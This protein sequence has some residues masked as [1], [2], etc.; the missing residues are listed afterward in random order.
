[1]KGGKLT[2]TDLQYFLKKSYDKKHSNYKDFVLDKEL[3]GQRVQVYYNP[4]TNQAVVVH[5]GTQGLNDWVTDARYAL[6]DTSSTRFQHSANIQAKAEKKYGA[7]NVTSIGHSLGSQLAQKSSGKKVKEIIT[8]NK[9]VNANDIIWHS[10]PQNQTDIRTSFDPVS[11][12]RPL[13]RGK[14]A[15]VLPSKTFNPFLEHRTDVLGDSPTMYG[16]GRSNE[17]GLYAY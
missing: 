17:L 15:V 8:L 3:T 7:T 9:P 2:S 12:L 5:R 1:M 10:V 14:K 4:K 16:S 6:G 13:E 11:V